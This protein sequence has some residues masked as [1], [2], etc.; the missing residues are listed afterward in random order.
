MAISDTNGQV[1]LTIINMLNYAI[2]TFILYGLCLSYIH[3]DKTQTKH[4]NCN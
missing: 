3:D 4:S 2:C 1:D